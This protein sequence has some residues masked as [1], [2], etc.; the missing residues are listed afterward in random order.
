[1]HKAREDL[2]N[3]KADARLARK[4]H[5]QIEYQKVLNLKA[6]F[7][8]D[9]LLTKAR[10]D[11]HE[12]PVT[13]ELSTDFSFGA[14][15]RGGVI[16][17]VSNQARSVIANECVEE[18]QKPTRDDSWQPMSLNSKLENSRAYTERRHRPEKWMRSTAR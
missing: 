2:H 8:N 9:R 13:G 6:L 11:L 14:Q 12:N 15:I 3:L 10:Y 7:A 17:N 16:R 5:D 1:M 18:K 4:R